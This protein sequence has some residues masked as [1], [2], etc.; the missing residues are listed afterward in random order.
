MTSRRTT[1]KGR[2]DEL[3]RVR[4]CSEPNARAKVEHPYP[5]PGC[6]FGFDKLRAEV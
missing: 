3:Q 2:V 5:I 6:I 4:N 1:W